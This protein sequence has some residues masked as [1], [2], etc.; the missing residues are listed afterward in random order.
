MENKKLS[1][2]ILE[3]SND[4]Y[5]LLL[6]ELNKAEYEIEHLLVEDAIGF[7]KALNENWDIIISDYALPT[8]T[9]FDALK[10]C[11]EKGIDTPFI[12]VSGTVGE[13]IAV[14]MMRSGARDYIMKNSLKRLLPA[15]DRELE[16]AKIRKKRK[17]TEEA[18]KLSEQL[19]RNLFSQA[20]EGLLLTTL[21]GKITEVNQAFAELHG[22]TVDELKNKN[23]KEIHIHKSP[24]ELNAEII[25]LL[26]DKEVIRIE[27]EHLHKD[28]HIIP[29]S[30]TI[31]KINNNGE[32]YL[33][34]FQDITERKQAEE[35]I[36]AKMDNLTLFKEL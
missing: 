19:Y 15:I 10:K 11:I 24:L 4:D 33:C 36:K 17:Q 13:D 5:L 31:N 7:E 20:Q 28:S 9:G 29:L 27:L 22:Y 6:R 26:I 35:A 2:L 8:Y 16:D 3:D 21:D 25:H 23:L 32:F 14:D 30:V 1:V 34:F 18:L 12:M